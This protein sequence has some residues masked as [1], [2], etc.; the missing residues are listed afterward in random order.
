ML[1]NKNPKGKSRQA[2]CMAIRSFF[3]KIRDK[4]GLETVVLISNRLNL[5]NKN[6]FVVLSVE[7]ILKI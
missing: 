1:A 5:I 2:D 6:M 7:K 3:D 4:Y